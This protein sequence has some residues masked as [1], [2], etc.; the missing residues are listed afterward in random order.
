MVASD[1]T[2]TSESYGVEFS[3]DTVRTHTISFAPRLENAF[4]SFTP[5]L[6]Y[7]FLPLTAKSRQP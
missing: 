6:T 7:G 4:L 5:S 3:E 2:L 1:G